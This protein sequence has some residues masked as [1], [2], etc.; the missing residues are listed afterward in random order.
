M[1]AHTGGGTACPCSSGMGGWLGAGLA[2]ACA[3]GALGLGGWGLGGWGTGFVLRAQ[4]S[5]AITRPHAALLLLLLLLLRL[6]LLL[7]RLLR[8]LLLYYHY[9]YHTTSSSQCTSVRR[10]LDEDLHVMQQRIRV[11][12]GAVDTLAWW[13]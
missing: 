7:L 5:P 9:H 12:D 8:P 1:Q 6:L 2:G 3:A 11:R 13:Q 10:A 4:S